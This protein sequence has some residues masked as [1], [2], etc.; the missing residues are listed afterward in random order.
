M[1]KKS[2]DDSTGAGSGVEILENHPYDDGP[3]GCG[4]Y[5][6]K[7]YHVSNYLPG[8]I[9]GLLPKIAL[10]AE[11]E[12]WNAYPYTKTRYSC[13]SLEKFSVDIDTLYFPDGGHQE[14]VFNLE[15][16]D[17]RNRTVGRENVEFNYKAKTNRN[18]VLFC[19]FAFSFKTSLILSK[20]SLMD[21]NTWKVKIHFCIFQKK[22][23]VAH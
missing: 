4:Q 6:R 2:R 17:L 19:V 8:W 23:I 3:G 18:K 5:T 21:T 10:S 20:N 22:R 9:K 7:I 12:A 15:G 14:N 13:Q 11:E 16:S 1:Q